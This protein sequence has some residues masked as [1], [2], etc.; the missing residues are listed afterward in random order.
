MKAQTKGSTMIFT[1]IASVTFYSQNA[2]ISNMCLQAGND[3]KL[4]KSHSQLKFR[5]K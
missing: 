3:R 2:G 1:E 4:L 5:D